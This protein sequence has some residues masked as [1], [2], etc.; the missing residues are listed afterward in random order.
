MHTGRPHLINKNKWLQPVWLSWLVQF[1]VKG[2]FPKCGLNSQWGCARGSPSILDIFHS[3]PL[4]LPL[5]SKINKNKEN[6][7]G[8]QTLILII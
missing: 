4:F 3:L 6:N 8:A 7:T 1:W 2:I 5:L